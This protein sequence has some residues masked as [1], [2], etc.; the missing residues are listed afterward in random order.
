MSLFSWRL[1]ATS[2]GPPPASAP[3]TCTTTPVTESRTSL[4]DLHLMSSMHQLHNKSTSV[5]PS[6]SLLCVSKPIQLRE[7]T[8]TVNY[9]DTDVGEYRFSLLLQLHYVSILFWSVDTVFRVT[10][11]LC[12]KTRLEVNLSG[13]SIAARNKL[14]AT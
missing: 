3:P 6:G 5:T 9:P 12:R 11:C 7:S 14:S 13:V 8:L 1:L 2:P 10:F 4:S